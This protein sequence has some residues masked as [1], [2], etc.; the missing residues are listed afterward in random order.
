MSLVVFD[1]SQC[2]RSASRQ[3][4]DLRSARG[5]RFCSPQCA[6]VHR[7]GK[8]VHQTDTR[9]DWGTFACSWCERSFNRKRSGVKT[10][11]P[12]CSYSCA[13]KIR[14][15]VN[16]VR[17][18]PPRNRRPGRPPVPCECGAPKSRKSLKCR[19]CNAALRART[20][21][22]KFCSGCSR[23][24]PVESFQRRRERAG[25]F[26]SR[27][28]T[29]STS[30]NRSWKSSGAP[31]ARAY[32][33][34]TRRA[35]RARAR[36]AAKPRKRLSIEEVRLRRNVKYRRRR[37]RASVRLNENFRRRMK[38]SINRGTKGGRSWELLVGY[39]LEDLRAHLE[40]SFRPGMTWKN[41]GTWHIDHVRPLASFTFATPDDPTFR[42][43]WALTN[44][45]PLW[46]LE[47]A[48][49][50]ARWAA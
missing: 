16:G 17:S 25:G 10:D 37:L 21:A 22:G 29:C 8:N 45:Q 34:R 9:A 20:A 31:T 32:V 11:T 50:G 35:A 44:L 4:A 28:R 26:R 7:R 18:I 12:A 46:A 39:T 38:Y 42:E 19:S 5:L 41:Y 14:I 49:K 33:E 1:C 27:C 6:G 48:R 2:G 47:N 3:S 24:L 40:A 13:A 43:A 36:L 30:Q 23:V 15:H